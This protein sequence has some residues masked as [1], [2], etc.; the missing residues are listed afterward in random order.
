MVLKVGVETGAE[1][2]VDEAFSYWVPTIAPFTESLV[3]LLLSCTQD[4]LFFFKPSILVDV[5]NQPSVVHAVQGYVD[6][7]G[8]RMVWVEYPEVG[9]KNLGRG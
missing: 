6:G 5:G 1:P 4:T 9:I 7:G 2:G 8:F 3:K